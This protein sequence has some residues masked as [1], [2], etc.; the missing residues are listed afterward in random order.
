M[1][2]S[3]GPF[4]RGFL[5]SPTYLSQIPVALSRRLSPERVPI[6]SDPRAVLE[7]RKDGLSAQAGRIPRPQGGYLR[8]DPVRSSSLFK[9]WLV[10]IQRMPGSARSAEIA[11]TVLPERLSGFA[12]SFR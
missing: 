12:G 11:V 1:T 10:P 3:T 2:L 6:Q 7:D 5:M 8:N 4:P 9:P